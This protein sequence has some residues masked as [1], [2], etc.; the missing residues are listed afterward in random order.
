MVN[1][2]PSKTKENYGIYYY[3]RRFLPVPYGLAEAR[4]ASSR[5]HRCG[6]IAPLNVEFSR[7]LHQAARRSGARR[8]RRQAGC[9]LAGR[10]STRAA[11]HF[12]RHVG[13]ESKQTTKTKI[14]I[15]TTLEIKGDWNIT[16][17]KLKQ[18]WA[19]LTDDDLQFV[20]ASRKNWLAGFRSARAKPAKRS[21]RP[22]RNPA[23]PAAAN[24]MAAVRANARR[25]L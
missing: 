17:G 18:K 13:G 14:T 15:M 25:P 5:H 8:H 10:A 4:S 23:P 9:G 2:L 3:Y 11:K 12:C 16:K 6:S 21:K 7:R 22:S 19:K 20:E 24:R 1:T